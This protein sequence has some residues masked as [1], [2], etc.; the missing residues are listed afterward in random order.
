[1]TIYDIQ[2]Q[3]LALYDLASD[4]DV[5]WDVFEDT[6][7][8][9]EGDLEEK[10]IN[11]GKV[12]RNL[13]AEGEAIKAE[14]ERLQKQKKVRENSVERMKAAL[15]TAMEIANKPKIDTALFK[16]CIRKN[17]ASVVIDQGA[18]VPEQFLVPQDPKV[19]KTALK[20]ALKAGEEFE[21]IHL[22]QGTSLSIK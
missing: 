1:M 2:N 3:F 12:I 11:Y 13:E 18:V 8:G 4:P 7:E 10:A 9:L 14:I 20:E 19:D 6:L 15:K 16:F 21:G 17:P 22:E 5:D